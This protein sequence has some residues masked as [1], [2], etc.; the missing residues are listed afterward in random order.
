[1]KVCL[2]AINSKYVHTSPAVDSLAAYAAAGG[3]PAGSLSFTVNQPAEQILGRIFEEEASVYCFSVYIW[4]VETVLHLT[5]DL[6]K[7]RPEAEI[8]LGGPEVSWR[9]AQILRENVEVRGIMR[10]EGEETFLELLRQAY[11]KDAFRSP[12]GSPETEKLA[13]IP[14]ISYRDKSGTI[15]E[16]GSRPVL[17]ME[18]LVFPYT[19]KAPDPNRIYYYESSRGCPFSCTYCLSS[20]DR[21]LRF[22]S[23]EKTEEELDWFLE[24]KVKQ[25]KFVDRTFNA[26]RTRS[27][28]IWRYL[29]EHDNGITNFHFEICGEL[30]SQEE[31]DFL[32]TLRPGQVQ[33]EIGVQTANPETLKTIRRV[34][35]EEKLRSN[36]RSLLDGRNIH[37]H[38]DLIAG[39]PEEDAESFRR[40]FNTVYGMHPLQL[41]LGFLKI[42][43]GTP[44]E[45]YARSHGCEYSSRPPY[46]ILS[47]PSMSYRD[48]LELKAVEEM[49]EVYYNSR[50][51]E[52][53]VAQLETEYTGMPDGQPRSSG[54]RELHSRSKGFFGLYLDLAGFHRKKGYDRMDH[55]RMRRYEILLEFIDEMGWDRRTYVPLLLYDAAARER[56]K[57][58]PSWAGNCPK[59][60]CFDYA[61]KDPLTG[62]A[63]VI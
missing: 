49:V 16:N 19:G 47:G 56:L 36:V 18:R 20:V 4:N 60:E 37:I 40:S 27:L 63:S 38:L 3:E 26:D 2:I 50:Q 6:K 58:W 31:L 54:G 32:K 59:P 41:Q 43:S 7:I 14:G 10:G 53:T 42:L 12:D 33:F 51:F 25:V 24:N 1:M 29:K 57:H 13:G 11:G 9:A 46:E 22:K 52:K 35:N 55:A 44:M 45:A 48:L 62:N 28:R 39:L 34:R 61:R 8:W 21:T 15:K 17:E 30:L 23:I 5:K